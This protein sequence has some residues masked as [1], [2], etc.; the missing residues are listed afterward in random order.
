MSINLRNR[1]AVLAIRIVFGAFMAFSG[2]SGLMMSSSL[3]GVPESMVPTMRVLLDTG[4]FYMIKGTEL[5]AGLMLV[6]GL[7]PSLAAIF[8]APVSIGILIVNARTNPSLLPM[9]AIIVAL[10]VYLGYA[11]WD[12][13]KALFTR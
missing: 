12:K 10:N 8:F 13:Y 3:Q 9:S 7:F 6:T 2:A 5:L 1:K 4:I 11:Y